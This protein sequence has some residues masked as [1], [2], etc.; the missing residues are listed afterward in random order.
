M[1][2]K[3]DKNAIRRRKHVRVR[4]KI[5]GTS[6]RPRLCVFRSNTNIYAQII[7][8]EAGKTLVSASSLDKEVKASIENGSN[9][10]G[11]AAVGKKIA[12]RA[13]AAN[14]NEVVFDRGGYIFHGRVAA[15]AEAAREAGL[16]F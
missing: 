15:L 13:L 6:S 9:K 7:D 10:E 14:I 1:I 16:K 8:D 12:E 4:N 2:N 11:A 5:A 3:I